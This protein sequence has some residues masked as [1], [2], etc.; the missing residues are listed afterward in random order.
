[1]ATVIQGYQC[2]KLHKQSRTRECDYAM[3]NTHSSKTTK[4]RKETDKAISY[5][6]IIAPRTTMCDETLQRQRCRHVKWACAADTIQPRPLDSTALHAP[7]LTW[8]EH[9]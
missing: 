6:Q 9:G 7:L 5:A 2:Q 4:K 8:A 1:M 3:A